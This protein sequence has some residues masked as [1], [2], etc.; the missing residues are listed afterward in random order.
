M[1]FDFENDHFQRPI[2]FQRQKHDIKKFNILLLAYKQWRTQVRELGSDYGLDSLLQARRPAEH[3]LHRYVDHNRSGCYSGYEPARGTP[4]STGT[5][6]SFQPAH[7]PNEVLLLSIEIHLRLRTPW[8]S[9]DAQTHTRR[10]TPAELRYCSIAAGLCV[11]Q[12]EN[13]NRHQCGF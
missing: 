5:Q 3:R 1:E 2:F 9:G 8:G 6:L 13:T 11:E 4:R 12:W 7:S 10:F